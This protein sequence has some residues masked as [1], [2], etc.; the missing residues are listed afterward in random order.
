MDGVIIRG[1]ETKIASQDEV[2]IE[3][4]D[5]IIVQAK[6]KRLGMSLLGQAFFSTYLMR[7][8]KPRS[9]ES[10]ALCLKDDAKL[11]P[12]L[13]QFQEC[14]VVVVPTHIALSAR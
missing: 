4:K 9:I 11:R 7:S 14:K 8:F 1:G 6:A 13:E 3:G 12:L 5:I 2:T 10:V